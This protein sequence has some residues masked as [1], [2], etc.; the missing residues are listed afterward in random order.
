[1]AFQQVLYSLV[2]APY[3]SIVVPPTLL[4]L[5]YLIVPGGSSGLRLISMR[6]STSS[7]ACRSCLV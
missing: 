1:M 6:K 2:V 3:R 4:L 5:G 7:F